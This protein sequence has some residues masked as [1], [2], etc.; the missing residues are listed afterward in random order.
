MDVDVPICSMPY[1]T[2]FEKF[3]KD[4]D[5]VIWLNCRD[6]FYAY[7]GHKNLGYELALA[8]QGNDYRAQVIST[9]ISSGLARLYKMMAQTEIESTNPV[10]MRRVTG[11]SHLFPGVPAI[12]G[13]IAR[14]FRA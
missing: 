10:G 3:Q 12:P 14:A 8:H 1:P 13:V 4:Y 9:H 2:N 5:A 7:I 6:G 11:D